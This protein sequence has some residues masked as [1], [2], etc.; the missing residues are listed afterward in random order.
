MQRL[1]LGYEVLKEVKPD[2][3]K[4]RVQRSFSNSS[5]NFDLKLGS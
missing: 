5:K 1:G 2:I 4:V 3:T